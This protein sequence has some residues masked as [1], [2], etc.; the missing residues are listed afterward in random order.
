LIEKNQPYYS[1]LKKTQLNP[2]VVKKSYQ[3]AQRFNLQEL[4]KIYR[5]IFQADLD[6]KTG[7]TE[8]ETA[9]DLFIAEI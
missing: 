7:K 1:I 5:K 8:P 3:Q 2:F 9:L 4:K 6:I